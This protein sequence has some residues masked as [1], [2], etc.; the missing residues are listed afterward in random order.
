GVGPRPGGRAPVQAEPD[1]RPV[2]PVTLEERTPRPEHDTL[3][4]KGHGAPPGETG[5]APPRTA[6]LPTHQSPRLGPAPRPGGAPGGNRDSPSRF[7][8]PRGRAPLTGAP[9]GLPPSVE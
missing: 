5:A 6:P 8:P 7:P 1:R 9:A 2:R 4:E 3:P